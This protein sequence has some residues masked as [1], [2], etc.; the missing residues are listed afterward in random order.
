MSVTGPGQVLSRHRAALVATVALLLA[1]L[2]AGIGLLGVSAG[3]LTGAA[4]SFGVLGGFNLFLPS[5][6]IRA[7]TMARILSRYGEKLVGHETTLRIARDLRVWLFG[8]MLSLSPGQLSRLRTGDLLARL[9]DDIDAVDG[10]LVRAIGPLLA[11]VLAALALVPFA[12]LL[13][14]PSG[15]WI[16]VVCGASAMIAWWGAARGHAATALARQR[17]CLRASLHELHDGA[18]DLAAVDATG[19]WLL[20][21]PGQ[22]AELALEER[23]RR[24]R[25]ADIGALQG[26]AGAV[27]WS[28]LLWLVCT[29]VVEGRLGADR[30]AGLAFAALALSEML[31]GMALA[32]QSLQAARASGSRIDALAGQSPAVADPV[33]PGVLPARGALVLDSVAF[34]WP[35]GRRVLDGAELQLEPG[36]R[37]AIRG[38]SG[39][40][41]SS[42]AALALRL[43]DPLAGA[44]RWGG[45][46]LREVAQADWH[47]RLAWLPQEAPVF[48][49]TLA[50]NLRMGGGGTDEADLHRLLAALRLEDWA[51]AAGGLAAWI[52]EN[53]ATVSAGQA[54]RIAL[55]RAL[56]RPVPLLVLDEPTDGLDQDTA[57]AVMGA[58]PALC[59]DRSV[60]LIS[61]APLPPGVV[62]RELLLSEGR[63]HPLA[64]A[65]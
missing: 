42:L 17:A 31:P 21:L 13:D 63:L 56:L 60:L 32:W 58:L 15:A 30:A 6:G 38:D 46:D 2:L 11:L 48:A 18:A 8:R 39:I 55:A 5:A 44:V 19:R 52:G 36:E 34:A 26:V 12:L 61:H 41:K 49:G 4:L 51:D 20:R 33:R 53:G 23:R 27:G 59:G 57:D 50:R 16:A 25:L 9:L 54:R 37:V 47:A 28:V 22:A 43:A 7:L 24:L 10:L 64:R 1:T 40:G 45:V 14:P 3:F 35:G 29:A 65:G 62:H